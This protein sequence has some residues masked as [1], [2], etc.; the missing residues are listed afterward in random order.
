MPWGTVFVKKNKKTMF[1]RFIIVGA[2]TQTLRCSPTLCFCVSSLTWGH[3]SLSVDR[4]ESREEQVC[5]IRECVFFRNP[6]TAV[7]S[8]KTVPSTLLIPDSDSWYQC[9]QTIL[10]SSD[11]KFRIATLV[12]KFSPV[13]LHVFL[14]KWMSVKFIISTRCLFKELES[15]FSFLVGKLVHLNSV[16]I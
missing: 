8:I 16:Y 9:A 5:S 15:V 14:K 1:F 6:G 7:S 12:H 2:L 3:W 11:F 10:V 4:I 13:H